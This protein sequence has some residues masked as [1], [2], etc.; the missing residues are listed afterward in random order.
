[1]NDRNNIQ[2]Y[3]SSNSDRDYIS[4]A[5]INITIIFQQKKHLLN[6]L[7]KKKK[8]IDPQRKKTEEAFTDPT[9][10]PEDK[11]TIHIEPI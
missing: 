4:Q 11:V 1:M 9:K 10:K 6:P 7:K 3:R 5:F 2:Y 8:L